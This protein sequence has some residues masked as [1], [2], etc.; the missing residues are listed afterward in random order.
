MEATDFK[1]YFTTLEY[2]INHIINMI[3]ATIGTSIL[4]NIILELGHR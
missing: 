4:E 3:S 1:N 2:P